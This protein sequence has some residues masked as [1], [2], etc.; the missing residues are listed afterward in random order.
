MP[1]KFS[2]NF[3]AIDEADKINVKELNTGD[4]TRFNN[5]GDDIEI[6]VKCIEPTNEPENVLVKA[7]SLTE[8]KLFSALDEIQFKVS[9]DTMFSFVD[10]V[11]DNGILF[12]EI[13]NDD[14]IINKADDLQEGNITTIIDNDTRRDILIT[15]VDTCPDTGKVTI[16]AKVLDGSNEAIKFSVDSD[17]EFSIKDFYDVSSDTLFSDRDTKYSN[18]SDQQ[19]LVYD[20]VTR[21]YVPVQAPKKKMSTGAKVALGALGLG[22]AAL[23]GNAAYNKY[24]TGSFDNSWASKGV[25]GAISGAKK[26]PE[27]FKSKEKKAEEAAALHEDKMKNDPIYKL[28]YESK[29]KAKAAVDE[30]KAKAAERNLKAQEILTA[31]DLKEIESGR[32]SNLEDAR[33]IRLAAAKA[34]NQAKIIEDVRSKHGDKAVEAITSGGKLDLAKFNKFRFAKE[35]KGNHLSDGTPLLTRAARGIS[36]AGKQIGKGI[37]YTAEGA[38]AAPLATGAA[39]GVLAGGIVGGAA[40]TVGDQVDKLGKGISESINNKKSKNKK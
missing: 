10:H 6:A 15:K 25:K 28:N 40:K 18:F 22:A 35:R 31:K 26:V 23:A 2:V 29:A 37:V 27:L 38:V 30:A 3:A 12:S 16:E 21:S 9:S 24:K 20:P 33:E 34:K 36:T 5:L 7:I 19:Q 32:A 39:A 4:I 8:G 14:P 11:Y 1:G 13:D 17:V